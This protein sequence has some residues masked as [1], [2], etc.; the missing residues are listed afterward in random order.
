MVQAG[1]LEAEITS[2]VESNKVVVYSK[3]YCKFARKVKEDFNSAGIEYKTFEVDEMENGDEI[4]EVLGELTGLT[5]VPNVF[6]NGVHIGGSDE[7]EELGVK[8]IKRMIN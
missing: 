4:I 8:G 3:S 6:V 1:G 7:V 5:T 2:T